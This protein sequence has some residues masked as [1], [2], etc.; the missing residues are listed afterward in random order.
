ML[1]VFF[2]S[3]FLG[4]GVKEIKGT[5]ESIEVVMYEWNWYEGQRT[6]TIQDVNRELAIAGKRGVKVRV[7]LHNE[8]MGRTLGK[9]NR[10]TAGHLRR[11]GVEVKMGNTGLTVHGKVWVFDKERAI[12]G[13]HNISSRSVG[14]NLEVGVLFDDEVEVKKVSEWFEEVWGKGLMET[15]GQ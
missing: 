6:G 1:R 8:A 13:S 12:V 5:K 2:S 10:K 11:A 15:R 14:K 7:L 4:V 9:I 3:E